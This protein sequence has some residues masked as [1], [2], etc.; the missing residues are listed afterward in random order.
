[1]DKPVDLDVIVSLAKR[2]GFVFQSS[3]IYG[4]FA[5]HLGLRP[6]R[7]RAEA[8][9]QERLVARHGAGAR[10]RGRPR[11][12]RSSCTRRS[13]RRRGH[14][15]NFTDPM[16]DCKKC[17]MRFRADQRRRADALPQLR[18]R[19]D[20]AAQV[21]P[22]VQDLRRPG[23]RRRGGRPTCA[24]RRRRASSSTSTT[25]SRRC[26]ASCRSASRRSASRSATRSRPATSSSARAS[27]S[28][29]RW[30]TSCTPGEDDELVSTHWLEDALQL[31]RATR[32]Q[33]GA[34]APA[35]ARRPKLSH[36]SKA[37]HRHRVPLPVGLGRAGG[38]RQPHRLRPAPAHG[39]QRQGPDATSTR[40][41]ARAT[42]PTSIEPAVGVDRA[43][44]VFLLDAYDEETGRATRTTRASC[45]ASHP[46]RADQ[47]RRAAA[48]QEG[49]ADRSWRRRSTPR[50]RKRWMTPV[51]PDRRRHRPA[52]PPPGRDRHAALRHG[53]LRQPRGPRRDDPRAR[54]DGPGPR[55]DRR[56][57]ARAARKAGLL[58]RSRAIRR[59]GASRAGAAAAEEYAI[60]ETVLKVG[61]PAPDFT[62]RTDKGETVHLSDYRGKRVV[63]YFYPK[64]DTPGS[65]PPPATPRRLP[66]D[67][68]AQRGRARREPRRRGSASRKFKTKFDLPFTLLVDSDHAIA[69]AYGVWGEPLPHVRQDVHGHP[70]QP[71]RHRRARPHRRLAGQGQPHR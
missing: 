14:V 12:R 59:A 63:I 67:R 18:R 58:A 53:R 65:T 57:R 33:A 40:R 43:A 37:H 4:G 35:R 64:D 61:D 48:L 31:V 45:C 13:G 56:S 1:M 46:A 5:Q 28:R 9:H 19:A 24:R 69:E 51:R 62:A 66:A 68:G 39:G 34:P 71:L 17:K 25:C 41:P 38:H 70:A 44:L 22:D 29:W 8:Q 55:A 36:Y 2:R 20:R 7:R 32:H 27:S 50:V 60:S 15:A 42:C 26:A 54:L 6:A 23:R 16:V 47:G 30:S 21:Q 10:R 49:A 52:L 11:Q 3:E